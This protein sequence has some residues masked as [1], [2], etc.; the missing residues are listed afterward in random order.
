VREK[1]LAKAM[2]EADEKAYAEQTEAITRMRGMLEDENEQ[3]RQQALKELQAYNKKLA[4]EKRMR[5]EAWK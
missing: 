4:L 3:K 2:D 1:E 5:E